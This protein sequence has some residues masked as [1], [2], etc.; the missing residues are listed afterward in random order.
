MLN[1]ASTSTTVPAVVKFG[2]NNFRICN[3]KKWSAK[4]NYCSVTITETRGTSSGFTKHLERQHKKE[5]S[6]YKQSKGKFTNR[7]GLPE[8]KLYYSRLIMPSFQI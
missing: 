4:C 7:V 6:Q 1:M 2:Y 5:Y 3:E 8:I